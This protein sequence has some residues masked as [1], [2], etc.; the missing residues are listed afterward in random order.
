MSA[1][2]WPQHN[3]R[4]LVH[5]NVLQRLLFSQQSSFLKIAAFKGLLWN[6]IRGCKTEDF[7]S[8]EPLCPI[9]NKSLPPGLKMFKHC[10]FWGSFDTLKLSYWSSAS[11]W[12]STRVWKLPAKV[13]DFWR[14]GSLNC[15]HLRISGGQPL[16]LMFWLRAG[17]EASGVVWHRAATLCSIC[18]SDDVIRGRAAGGP[19]A[20]RAEPEPVRIS[21]WCEEEISD[22]KCR[23]MFQNVKKNNNFKI[24]F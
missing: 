7:Y 16:L 9:R 24:K 17:P 11:G 13:A 3:C 23:F 5:T 4:V 6:F 14:S 20:W 2:Q 22:H 21:V 12:R 18:S 10:N 1:A 19:S 8:N 15:L